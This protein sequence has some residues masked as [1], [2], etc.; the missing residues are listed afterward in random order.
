L[1]YQLDLEGNVISVFPTLTE[2]AE[3]NEIEATNIR[4]VIAG[5]RNTAG[6]SKWEERFE[7]IEEETPKTEHT[8]E[9]EYGEDY[10]KFTGVLRDVEINT[11]DDLLKFTKVDL[12]LW[13]VK[14]YTTKVWTTTMKKR[15]LIDSGTA[16]PPIP[17][18]GFK[19]KA[20]YEHSALQVTNV[21]FNVNFVHRTNYKEQ[22]LD[23]LKTHVAALPTNPI[24]RKTGK[25]MVEFL[26]TDH[27]LGKHGF[28]SK[29]MEFC[30]DIPKAM[31]E[32]SKAIDF[33]LS[34]INLDEVEYFVLPTGNDLLH[35]DNGAGTT[36]SGMKISDELF[37]LNLFRYAKEAV[38]KSVQ[39]LV[40]HA[41]VKVIFIPGNHDEN[42]V[43]MLSEVIREMFRD[44]P[45]VEV[46]CRGNGRE[47][48]SFGVNL[49][50][51]HHGKSN[52]PQKASNMMIADVP[53]LF[54]KAKYR[55]VHVG[56]THT[57]SKTNTVTL[58]TQKEEHG[59]I[60]EIC[61]ALCPSDKWHDQNLY[62]GNLRRSKVFVYDKELG[63]EAE[64]YY[65]I[66]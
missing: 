51:W 45:S 60:Y 35:V 37:Y 39:K 10:V 3:A 61:P 22:L 47:Y 2:A 12:N 13:E 5:R 57:S 9:H 4:A 8:I 17:G 18:E 52:N 16:A 40:Q 62:I 11:L 36:T 42:A 34:Q 59:I 21:G 15:T 55:T 27:H 23:S 48:E 26:V 50:G 20:L 66:N 28:D 29:T 63:L 33:G 56:H 64:Y 1:I 49:I 58:N 65:T 44:N 14:N 7:E 19:G 53:E 25:K 46:I 54:A 30:W 31:E 38:A 32:Y 24:Q 43:L 6:G 41:P